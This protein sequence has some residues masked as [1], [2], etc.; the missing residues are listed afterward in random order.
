MYY[1]FLMTDENLDLNIDGQEML[2][3]GLDEEKEGKKEKSS[4]WDLVKFVIIALIVII[5]MRMWVLSPYIVKGISMSPT[6]KTRD[7]VI[8]NKISYRFRE[9]KL[10]EVIILRNPLKHSQFFIKRIMGTPNQ[11]IT[12]EGKIIELEAEEYYVMGDNRSASKDSRSF[13][14][15]N[16]DLI[17]GRVSLRL[18]PI[19][20]FGILPGQN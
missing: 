17:I 18:W 13:G 3:G 19:S 7:Y 4:F 2:S 10:G 8:S 5:P 12:V 1:V 20:G 14:P 15:I 9:P 11:T 16:K 6:F